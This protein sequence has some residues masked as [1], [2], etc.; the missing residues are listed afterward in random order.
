[1]Q[2]TNPFINLITSLGPDPMVQSAYHTQDKKKGLKF[3]MNPNASFKGTSGMSAH[4]FTAI[5]DA[6]R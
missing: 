5:V 6:D 1:M 3:C 2:G 4:K